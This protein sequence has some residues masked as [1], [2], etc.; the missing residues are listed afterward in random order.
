[1]AALRV[2]NRLPWTIQMAVNIMRALLLGALFLV[3]CESEMSPAQRAK[4]AAASK[5]ALANHSG[6]FEGGKPLALDYLGAMSK[7]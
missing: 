5:S 1:M 4:R 3:S 7:P 6:G 2:Q